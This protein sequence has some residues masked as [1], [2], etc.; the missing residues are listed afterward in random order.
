[1]NSQ[2]GRENQ[3]A[4]LDRI[5]LQQG[6]QHNLDLATLQSCIKAQS[7]EAVSASVR[8]AESLGVEATPTLFINGEKVDGAL[9]AE[10]LRAILDRALQ[11]AGVPAPAH[12]AASAESFSGR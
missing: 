8:E 4:A 6:Q 3:F 10:D 2:K 7:A 12:P 11:Q 1:V 5:T 9:P